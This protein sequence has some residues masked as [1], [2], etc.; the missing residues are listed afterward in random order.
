MTRDSPEQGGGGRRGYKWLTYG[1]LFVVGAVLA[2]V[3]LGPEAPRDW[4][5][6]VYRSWQ[7]LLWD[8]WYKGVIQWGD[9]SLQVPVGRYGWVVHEGGDL[10]VFPRD[11]S[12]IVSIVV[13]KA[14][15]ARWPFRRYTE[16][17]CIEKKLCSRFE[18]R[19]LSID[20]R[21]AE[22]LVFED[23][24]PNITVRANAFIYLKDPEVLLSIGAEKPNE[25][26]RAMEFGE[27]LLEQIVRQTKA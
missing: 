10:E 20:K 8:H 5:R 16:Q 4:G 2:A 15:R 26:E 17:T 3:L 14:E 27:G 6:S 18:Q 9:Y 1:G 19:S 11:S 23:A 12:G 7:G 21:S 24:G 22:V 13:K 25:L